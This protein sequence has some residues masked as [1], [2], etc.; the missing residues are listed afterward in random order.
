VYLETHSITDVSPTTITNEINNEKE[1]YCR[2]RPLSEAYSVPPI[3]RP[4]TILLPNLQTASTSSTITN[5]LANYSVVPTPTLVINNQ[6]PSTPT[7]TTSITSNGLN[8]PFQD[9]MKMHAAG[10][11]SELLYTQFTTNN[12][13]IIIIYIYIHIYIYYIHIYI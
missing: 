11:Y 10:K 12:Y 4:V 13:Y 1:D 7:S 6:L 8:L 3:A 2:P 5:P 9:Y